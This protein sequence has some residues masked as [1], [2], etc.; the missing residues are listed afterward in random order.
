MRDQGGICPGSAGACAAAAREVRTVFS[1]L[2]QLNMG[3]ALSCQPPFAVGPL[4]AGSR[5]G[6]VSGQRGQV[7]QEPRAAKRGREAAEEGGQ[8]L[9]EE[10]RVIWERGWARWTGMRGSL[11]LDGA[12]LSLLDDTITVT[13]I[14]LSY[15]HESAI[16]AAS[17][18]GLVDI[19][20]AQDRWTD[21]EW[22]VRFAVPQLLIAKLSCV[23]CASH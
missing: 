13:L 12:E 1:W 10:T 17:Q 2:P 18:G 20:A 19:L 11:D 6:A 5:L 4:L 3:L 22:I 7:S 21:G 23:P 16:T 15:R 8:H 14:P 9:R